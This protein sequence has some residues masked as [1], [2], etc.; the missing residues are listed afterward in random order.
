M[1]ESAPPAGSVRAAQH[2]EELLANTLE[3]AWKLLLWSAQPHLRGTPRPPLR[4]LLAQA[5]GTCV[6]SWLPLYHDMGL[7]SAC[8]PLLMGGAADLLSPMSFL[9]R[10]MCWLQASWDNRVA[11]CGPQSL[12]VLMWRR[13]RWATT[14]TKSSLTV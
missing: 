8:T 11:I 5:T 4:E 10:P 2:C 6:V 12:S 3:M 1:I 14:T 9:Q 13:E 7:V